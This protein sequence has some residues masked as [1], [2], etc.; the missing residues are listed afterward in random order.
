MDGMRKNLVYWIYIYFF[1]T[2]YKSNTIMESKS[3]HVNV[4]DTHS[5]P[6]VNLEALLIMELVRN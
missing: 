4:H 2:I 6:P 1:P 5:K 3:P